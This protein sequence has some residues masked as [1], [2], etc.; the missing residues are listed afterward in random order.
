[1]AREDSRSAALTERRTQ[2]YVFASVMPNI[3]FV[4]EHQ[5]IDVQAGRS[6]REIALE[7]GIYPNREFFRGF[8]CGGRGL[9][10][11]CK[12]W[13]H[14]PDKATS[15]PNLRERFHGMGD[16]RRLACQTRVLG[17]LEVAT[18][19]GGDDRLTAGRN[20]DPPPQREPDPE[21]PPAAKPAKPEAKKEAAKPA[22]DKDAAKPAEKGDAEKAEA[23]PE[24]KKE[25]AKPA[26]D[27][28]AAK[29]AEKDDAE[30]AEA[31]AEAKKDDAGAEASS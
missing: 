2:R 17:D 10:G 31:K 5:A 6:I 12:V 25:A 9:C 20:I 29:P 30:K 27:K 11:T 22:V 4:V 3:K 8:N 21:P 19:P 18:F 15:P 13:V 26:V 16:G 28:D 23:K 24:A 14:A 1:M 7:V